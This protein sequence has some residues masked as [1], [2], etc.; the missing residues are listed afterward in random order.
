MDD[1]SHYRQPRR[2]RRASGFTLVELLVVIAIIGVLVALLLPAL[3][4]AREAA[5]RMSC[6]NNMRQ[7]GIAFEGHCQAM[8]YYPIGAVAKEFPDLPDTPWSFYRWSALAMASPYLEN[9]AAL[10]AL[11]L[12][13]PLYTATLG[14]TPE[15]VAGSSVVVPVFL[16]PSDER[17]KV[18]AQFGPTNYAACAGTGAAGGNPE[19]ADGVYYVNSQVMPAEIRD[20]ASNTVVLSESILG[21]PVTTNPH[22]PQTEYKYVFMT[23]LTDALCNATL[24]WNVT[25]ARGFAWV[26][27]EYRCALYNHY[28][29]PNSRT[30]DCIANNMG[31]AGGAKTKYM[32]YG[33]R[34][35]RSRH[36]GGVNTLWGDGS[37]RFTYDAVEP[38]IWKAMATRAGGEV[39]TGG[40]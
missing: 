38:D 31:D 39:G 25:D 15:N 40:I 20:G 9:Q 10:N 35:A 32:V 28:M 26:S 19:N 30:P 6:A 3:Q 36:W 27:G 13:K 34:A 11:D 21:K 29:T 33:F 23:P 7:I 5:R 18:H 14:V 1:T 37:V 4:G 24:L 12:N 8:G 2:S 16:C 17:R 22:D